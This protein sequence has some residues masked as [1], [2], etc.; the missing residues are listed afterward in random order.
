MTDATVTAQTSPPR[1]HVYWH[2]RLALTVTDEPG[3]LVSALSPPPLPGDVVASSPFLSASAYL[4][5]VEDSLRTILS[6]SRSTGDF[7]DRVRKAGFSVEAV[8]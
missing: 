5:D 1:Y 6:E 2:G 4:P 8:R 3:P 7:L